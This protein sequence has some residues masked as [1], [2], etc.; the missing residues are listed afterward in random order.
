MHRYE[1]VTC[2][3]R[4]QE[5]SA[6]VCFADKTHLCPSSTL[7][8]GENILAVVENKWDTRNKSGND[9]DNFQERRRASRPGDIFKVL[10]AQRRSETMQTD[11]W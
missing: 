8:M 11:S 4:Y 2:Y 6:A 9:L 7:C 1:S 5:L 3:T 10:T